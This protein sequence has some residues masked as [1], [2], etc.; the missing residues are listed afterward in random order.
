MLDNYY[1]DEYG[2]IHQKE[3]NRFVYDDAYTSDYDKMSES[4]RMMSYLRFGYL[5]STIKFIPTS[6]LDVGYGNGS[7]ISTCSSVV[8]NCYGNDVS[9]YPIPDGIE[10]VDDITSRHFDV[11][12]FFDS[13][14]H[15][16]DISI[17]GELDCDYIMISLPWCHYRS[18]EWFQN[19]KH[20]RVDEHLHYFDEV[21]LVKYFNNFGF[22][23]V[24]YSNLEDTIRKSENV[25]N[26]LTAIFK[27]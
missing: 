10:Y 9:D 7:F 8:P 3:K 24:E 21:S 4:V 1:K 5:L 27:K 11:I 19:W 20:R 2:I 18:D 16:D 15:F 26:I 14:E 22:Q 13:L 12:T 6:I 17:I 25:N 23:L